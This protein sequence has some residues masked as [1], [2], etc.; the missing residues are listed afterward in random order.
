MNDLKEKAVKMAEGVAKNV[1][2][3]MK[4]GKFVK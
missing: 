3:M 4:V 2:G 1:E